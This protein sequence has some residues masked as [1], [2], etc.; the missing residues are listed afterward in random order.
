MTELQQWLADTSSLLTKPESEPERKISP[1]QAQIRDDVPYR[2]L[3]IKCL[4][5]AL[6]QHIFD[7]AEGKRRSYWARWFQSRDFEI[8]CDCAG[9]DSD[10]ALRAFERGITSPRETLSMLGHNFKEQSDDSPISHT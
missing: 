10:T 5:E 8:V 7:M 6:R 1:E 3:W 9:V 2:T 4:R